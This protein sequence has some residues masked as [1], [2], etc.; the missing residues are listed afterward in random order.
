MA[1]FHV[2]SGSGSG[3]DAPSIRK[4]SAGEVLEAL[5][6]GWAD[7]WAMPSHLAFIGLIY[8]VAGLVMAGLAFDYNLLPLLFPL[9]SGFALVGPLAGIFLYE[10]SRRRERGLSTEWTEVFDVLRSP[11]MPSVAALGLV[12]LVIFVAWI[13]TAQAIYQG[14]YGYQAPSSIPSFLR[15][16]LTTERGFKL[17]V[18]GKLVGFCFAV[19]V[20]VISFIAFPL[21][22]DRDVGVATA[23]GTSVRAALA[24][25]GPVA[26]WG[27]IVAGLLALGSLP[28]FVGLAIVVPV[29]GHATWHL[30]RLIVDSRP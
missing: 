19:V 27:M 18:I 10:I 28:L 13:L 20:L 16:V 24:N 17:V 5:R 6:K 22:L 14:L 1:E 29:L 26:L 12:L 25:P 8:P 23:V 9:A 7:F 11:A 2:L 30:Y 21:L 4:I 3:A 15:E